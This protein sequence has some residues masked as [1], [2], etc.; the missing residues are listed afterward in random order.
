MATTGGRGT[1]RIDWKTGVLYGAGAYLLGFVA[2]YVLK[3]DE[4]E[5]Q[6]QQQGFLGGQELPET[7]KLV[8][9]LFAEMHQVTVEAATSGTGG[10][11]AIPSGTR[12]VD[13][14]STPVWDQYLLVVPPLALVA[15]GYLLAGRYGLPSRAVGAK[16]GASLVAGYLPLAALVGYG[17]EWS[18]SASSSFGVQVSLTVGPQLVESVLLAG[19]LYP[20]LFGAIGGYLAGP[21]GGGRPAGRQSA[22][23]PEQGRE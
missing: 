21:S 19:L 13:L 8:S 17:A 23:P 4:V 10:G 7:W 20:L 9:W 6:L 22:R 18:Y 11:G 5:R 1:S 14:A 2:T 16:Y 3:A 15:G 12:A